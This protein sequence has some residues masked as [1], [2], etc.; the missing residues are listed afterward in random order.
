MSERIWPAEEVKKLMETAAEWG[1]GELRDRVIRQLCASHELLRARMARLESAVLVTAGEMD[2]LPVMTGP[3]GGNIYVTRE[4]V[5][6]IVN[7]L[8]L[9]AGQDRKY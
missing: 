8:R 4:T 9:A 7:R 6:L 5:A 1:D 2:S 3:F